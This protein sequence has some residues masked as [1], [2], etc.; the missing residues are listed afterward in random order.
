MRGTARF[1]VDSRM[2]TRI[3]LVR[4]GEPADVRG[5]CYGKLDVGLSN[6]GRAQ[7]ERTAACLKGEPFDAIYA[8]PRTRTVESAR[9]LASFHTCS[10][11]EDDGL[12]EIAFGDFEG[13]T[14]DEIAQRYPV[15]YRQWMESPT[16]VQF[17]NGESFILM[18]RRVL[19]AFEAI[20]ESHEGRTVAVVTHGGAIRILLAWVLQ[21]PHQAIFR[22]AQCYGAMNLLTWVEGIPIV[23]SINL[24]PLSPVP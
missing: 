19:R 3:W 16:E 4:H 15:L 10:W 9:I 8:S 12:C 13:L 1:S 14:Y 7:M 6:I 20:L 22:L 5:R 11:R 17:P 18:R 21:M 23:E 24:N 2:T